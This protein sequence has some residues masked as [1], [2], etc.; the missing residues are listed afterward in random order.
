MWD[1]KLSDGEVSCTNVKMSIK[2]N[3]C[4]LVFCVGKQY[5]QKQGMKAGSIIIENFY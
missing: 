1:G 5:E 2:F 4:E 3:A